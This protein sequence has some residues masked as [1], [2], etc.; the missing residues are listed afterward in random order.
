MPTL[1][2]ERDVRLERSDLMRRI[3]LPRNVGP[4]GFI[5]PP[6]RSPGLHAS[7]L[8]KYIAETSRITSYLEQI[9][10]DELPLK[11]ALG[12]A[13]EEYAASL[14]P[15]MVW[16]PDEI[17]KPLIMNVDGLTAGDY[18]L[19]VEEF[20]FVRAKKMET[21]RFLDPRV[22]WLKLQQGMIYC[23]GWGTDLVR[24]HIMNV[25][26]W[27]EPLYTTYLVRFEKDELIS[28]RRMIEVNREAAIAKGY[29]E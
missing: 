28:T 22:N 5:I 20:K 29:S 17:H 13:W 24:W 7:G 23:L 15:N 9:S 26:E 21:T 2:E 4:D 27:P 1:I 14:Y 19:V 10:E 11:W 25:I 6:K 8:L 18:S 3:V 12:L 16:Q